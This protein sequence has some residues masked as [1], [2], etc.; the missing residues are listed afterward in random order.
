MN[1]CLCALQCIGTPLRV[2]PALWP[3]P[4]GW[5]PGC[6][7][8]LETS[9]GLE[10]VRDIKSDSIYSSHIAFYF[11]TLCWQSRI[12]QAGIINRPTCFS[13]LRFGLKPFTSKVAQIIEKKVNAF[14]YRKISEH[15]V[16]YSLLRMSLSRQRVQGWL[17]N[18]Q[19]LQ[20]LIRLSIDVTGKVWSM[21]LPYM[22]HT[23]IP[24]TVYPPG[25][26]YYQGC[27]SG[28]GEPLQYWA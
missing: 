6:S 5:A 7:D 15:P 26:R 11:W 20:I 21:H 18:L 10:K 25:G 2:Y 28:R 17:F 16:H 9:G 4:L 3:D 22:Q 8:R 14:H 23:V 1:V 19:I 13:F 27:P 24:P 12:V